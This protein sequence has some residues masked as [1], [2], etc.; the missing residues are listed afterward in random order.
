M[1]IRCEASQTSPNHTS[2][3]RLPFGAILSKYFYRLR[4]G[5][6]A[7]CCLQYRCCALYTAVHAM[8]FSPNHVLTCRPLR[9][10]LQPPPPLPRCRYFVLFP[11]RLLIVVAGMLL[12]GVM[13]CVASTLSEE[14]K[15]RVQTSAVY[16]LNMFF[17]WSW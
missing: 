8:F 1:L 14:K 9:I 3:S 6:R 5:V 12:F 16:T 13:Y 11:I 7:V 17:L 4:I 2:S 15:L 10:P